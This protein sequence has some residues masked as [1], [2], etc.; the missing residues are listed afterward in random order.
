MHTRAVVDACLQGGNRPVRDAAQS[1]GDAA[2]LTQ[3]CALQRVPVDWEGARARLGARLTKLA[4]RHAE[5]AE[6]CLR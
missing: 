2:I 4:A 3:W 1:Q 6:T 5:D